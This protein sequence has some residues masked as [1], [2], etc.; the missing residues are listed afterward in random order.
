MESV[1]V[2]KPLR[3]DVYNELV[4]R[5]YDHRFAPGAVLRDTEL[6]IS[7]GVSR[8]PVREALIRLQ[9]DRLVD[10]DVG[11]GFRVSELQVSEIQQL[12]PII[13]TLEALAL[14]SCPAFSDERI[15][16]LKVLNKRLQGADTPADIVAGD[17]AWHRALLGRCANAE[18]GELIR[19][20]K[21]RVYRYELAYMRQGAHVKTSAARHAKIAAALERHRLGEAENLLI[22]NWRSGMRDLESWLTAEARERITS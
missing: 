21:T 8:T 20:L 2:R 9:Q 5:I 19:L 4:S 18:L 10:A 15:R 17:D 11:R 14:R 6:A 13:W 7:L 16:K 12:Y 1:I 22:E 3:Q